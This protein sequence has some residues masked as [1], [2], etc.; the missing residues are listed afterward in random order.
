MCVYVKKLYVKQEL[1]V[2]NFNTKNNPKYARTLSLGK[3]LWNLS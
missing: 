3:N 1:C 2:K